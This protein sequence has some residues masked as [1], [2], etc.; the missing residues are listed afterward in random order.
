MTTAI[1]SQLRALLEKAEGGKRK[2][3][4]T[5]LSY[6]LS[7]FRSPLLMETTDDSRCNKSGS[8]YFMSPK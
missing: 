4:E 3:E 2:A 7:A 8:Y 5:I 1:E 6:P